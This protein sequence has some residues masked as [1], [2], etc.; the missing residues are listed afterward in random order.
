VVG[1]IPD[2]APLHPGY[3]L[4]AASLHPGYA[5]ETQLDLVAKLGV[6]LYAQHHIGEPEED[7]D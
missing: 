6:Q 7:E 4:L 2:F 1:L 5:L 3:L